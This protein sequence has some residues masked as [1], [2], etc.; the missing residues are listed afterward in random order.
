MPTYDF[1]DTETGET[2][3]LVMPMSEVPKIGETITL[4]ADLDQTVEGGP[5]GKICIRPTPR[6][7]KRLPS[8]GTAFRDKTFEPFVTRQVERFHPDA[9]RVNARGNAVFHSKSEVRDFCAKTA[10]K[11]TGPTVYHWDKE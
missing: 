4:K 5:L 7:L 1:Q 10:D 11:N 6:T 3:E 2:V 8:S 9:P